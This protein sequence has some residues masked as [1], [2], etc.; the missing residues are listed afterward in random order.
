MRD[1]PESSDHDEP[2]IPTSPNIWQT[3]TDASPEAVEDELETMLSDIHDSADDTPTK[4]MTPV[5]LFDALCTIYP[6][7]CS[8][9]S[10]SDDIPLDTRYLYQWL[11]IALLQKI[12]TSLQATPSLAEML[13]H[14][15]FYIDDKDKRWGAGHTRIRINIA[16]IESK[17]EYR[18]VLTHELGHIIDLAVLQG[19]ARRK[20]DIFT[21]FGRVIRSEDDPSLPFYRLSWLNETTRKA[22]ASY[23]DFV[24]GYALKNIYEDFAETKNL[25]FNHKDLFRALAQTND[26]LMQK[27]L[28]FQQLYDDRYFSD[29]TKMLKN[30]STKTRVWDTTRIE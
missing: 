27:Y 18:E 4:K 11:M 10:W 13:E 15:A 28:F 9:T 24:S 22:N 8:K 5:E 2:I 1:A 7:E 17:Q 26:I 29:D 30:R 21:E 12:D 19:D 25:W 3:K 23:L 16:N 6:T 20:N 14:I